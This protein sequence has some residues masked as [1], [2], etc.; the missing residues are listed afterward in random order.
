[1]MQKARN[2]NSQSLLHETEVIIF[3]VKGENMKNWFKEK[4]CKVIIKLDAFIAGATDL[5][6]VL[7]AHISQK[8]EESSQ[9]D[10]TIYKL[11]TINENLNLRIKDLEEKIEKL[12]KQNDILKRNNL[13][14]KEQVKRLE[15][16]SVIAK[17]D[18][19]E[20]EERINQLIKQN[21]FLERSN[22]E[23]LTK[24]NKNYTNVKKD[25]I[26]IEKNGKNIKKY[27]IITNKEKLS[28]EELEKMLSEV[29]KANLRKLEILQ[30]IDIMK[31]IDGDGE[32][33]E[34]K[35]EDNKNG[36]SRSFK[37]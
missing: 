35:M 10:K 23:L 22:Y 12:I 18:N 20:L 21:S 19:V 7:L 14:F 32:I 13:N 6:R 1:M 25:D 36:D 28:H 26:N 29:K 37:R 34:D 30:Q 11:N 31:A 4:A 5:K 8:D 16:D 9:Q 33:S 27:D 24:L 17:S 3:L 2:V 15:E